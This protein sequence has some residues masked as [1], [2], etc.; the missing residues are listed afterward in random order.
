VTFAAAPRWLHELILQLP[1]ALQ[2]A[3]YDLAFRDTHTKVA[4]RF[5]A[6]R[7]ILQLYQWRQ[8]YYLKNKYN[9]QE[10]V[11]STTN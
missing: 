9:T 7:D 10:P 8:S 4:A 1:L 5:A 3:T 2:T 11:K 6:G